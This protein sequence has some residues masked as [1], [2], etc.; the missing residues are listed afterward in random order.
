MS[1]PPV[2]VSGEE[3][4]ALPRKSGRPNF[5]LII[6]VSAIIMSAISLFV[7]IENGISQRQL[8]AASTWPYLREIESND[9][10][11]G[12]DVAIGLSN[13]GV[14][15]AKIKSFEVFYKSAPVSSGL[16]LLRKCCGLNADAATEEKQLPGG[17]NYSIAD[18]T[19]LR[20]GEDN[21]VLRVHRTPAA[22]DIARRFSAVLEDV[23][24]RVCYCSILDECWSTDLRSTRST[25]V[26]ECRAPE[27]KFDPNGK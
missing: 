4:R 1:E 26:R 13:G 10:N 16:D 25:A 15:P 7:A 6:A 11:E 20:P 22:P 14:G 5:D 19:V 8:V 21:P 17:F 12:R 3:A 27:H 24:F 18:E 23:S 9:Y 2:E